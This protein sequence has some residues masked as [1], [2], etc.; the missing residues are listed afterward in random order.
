MP[1]KTKRKNGSIG[2]RERRALGI[3]SPEM[4]LPM[5]EDF[6]AVQLHNMQQGKIVCGIR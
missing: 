2:K 4:Q 3:P 6:V 1:P 5:Q